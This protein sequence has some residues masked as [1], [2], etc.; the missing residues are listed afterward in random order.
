MDAH[1]RDKAHGW[2]GTPDQTDGVYVEKTD[3]QA[4]QRMP[5]SDIQGW[6]ADLDPAMR[7]AVPME[8][9]P[10]R[11]ENVHWDAPEEQ[12]ARIRVFHSTERPGIT[13]VFGT[14]TPPSGVSGAV[15]AVAYKYAEN[16]MRHWLLLL[17]A[18]RVNV[19]EGLLD[20]L[21]H[22]HIPNLYKEMGGPAEWRHNR[23]GFIR[24]A[25]IAGAVV[26]TIYYLRRRRR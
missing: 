25:L 5:P 8:R 24:K 2:G 3:P 17:F 26:G 9:T 4:R 21:A 15:R 1:V 10:P 20:D 16:D 22:G 18:D 23:Q 13:P 7:P 19:V 6:G 11:L 12:P 14:S